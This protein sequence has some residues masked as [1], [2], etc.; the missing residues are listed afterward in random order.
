MEKI[1]LNGFKNPDLQFQNGVPGSADENEIKK[2]GVF[3]WDLPSGR[4]LSRF[5]NPESKIPNQ[6]WLFRVFWIAVFE[7]A[8]KNGEFKMAGVICENLKNSCIQWL[9]N[10]VK[11]SFIIR[12]KKRATSTQF[13]V[14][15][16]NFF[17]LSL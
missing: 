1:E 16:R 9:R 5:L 11:F 14:D 6:K 4:S 2:L 15:A 3:A 8:V 10:Q 13:A 7:F 17:N 12:S